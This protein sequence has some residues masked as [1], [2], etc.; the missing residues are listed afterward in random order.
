MKR[1]NPD[2]PVKRVVLTALALAATA[3]VV[4]FSVTLM[5][6]ED[7]AGDPFFWWSMVLVIAML[8]L[9]WVYVLVLMGREL[10]LERLYLVF[11]L[12]FGAVFLFLI[13]PYGTPDEATH[14]RGAYHISNLL[15][16]TRCPGEK[17]GLLLDGTA[18]SAINI[19]LCDQ[20]VQFANEF[21]RGVYNY[22]FTN[23][24]AA[25]GDTTLTAFPEGATTPGV[26]YLISGIAVA[27]G[28]LLH[29][30]PVGLLLFGS[31]VN[32]VL[33]VLCAYYSIRRA[34]FAKL[35]FFTV[36]LLPM[37]LQ[38]TSSYS[39]DNLILAAAL[40]VTSQALAHQEGMFVLRRWEW[41]LYGVA[42][43]V[44]VIA[45]G[46]AYV[47]LIFLPVL[48]ALRRE[49]ITKKRVLLF[50][51]FCVLVVLL[52]MRNGLYHLFVPSEPDAAVAG[53]ESGYYIERL[54]AYAYSL[55]D[56]LRAPM[57]LLTTV[58][59]TVI[60]SG[61]DLIEGMVGNGLG[62]LAIGIPSVVV[63]GFIGVLLLGVVP[64]K[65]ET[66]GFLGWQRLALVLVALSGIGASAMA[67]LL[68]WTPKDYGSIVG[69]QGRYF[70]PV[71]LPAILPL[72]SRVLQ[73]ER[74][75]TKWL[76]LLLLL[77]EFAAVFFVLYAGRV[78]RG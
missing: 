59:R 29:M 66:C 30:N 14:F 2:F 43:F 70:L 74:R 34:P 7:G 49:K 65:G 23:L 31:A 64:E 61:S 3:A 62:W 58:A 13:P 47:L 39:Y 1:L 76:I 51:G 71:L 63:Y 24:F 6:A 57:L 25:A 52:L 60:G 50:A 78:S 42:S 26:L 45:K 55:A 20:V 54:D 72:R 53:G 36:A 67:M 19:R 77:L 37:T 15:L 32:M 27:V 69:L 46:G 38:Q 44:L 21:D 8:V 40:V 28:R 48:L 33:F 22:L 16:G 18:G 10:P 5:R 17:F 35:A 9:T 12:F 11:G 41:A 56:Y 73:R 4:L 68:Y 75:L